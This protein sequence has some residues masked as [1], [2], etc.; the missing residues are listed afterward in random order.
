MSKSS[1]DTDIL[2]AKDHTRIRQALEILDKDIARLEGDMASLKNDKVEK[3]RAKKAALEELQKIGYTLESLESFLAKY[4]PGCYAREGFTSETDAIIKSIC[5][6]HSISESTKRVKS[7]VSRTRGPEEFDATFTRY[8]FTT[9]APSAFRAEEIPSGTTPLG[10]YDK[11]Q[12][13]CLD[14]YRASL[15]RELKKLENAY[16][17][18]DVA[19][20]RQKQAKLSVVKNVQ[21]YTS[22]YEVKRILNELQENDSERVLVGWRCKRLLNQLAK[23][24]EPRAESSRGQQQTHASGSFDLSL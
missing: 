10:F 12:R 18:K 2:I 7:S 15:E 8:T 19:Q 3:K 24:T 5:K 16:S 20:A 6:R 13:R 1:K 4:P 23:G 17:P 21:L 14:T 11:Q 9:D 22:Y